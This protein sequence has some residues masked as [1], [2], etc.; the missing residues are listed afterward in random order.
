VVPINITAN[1]EMADRFQGRLP[2]VF[3]MGDCGEPGKLMEAITPGFLA[4]QKI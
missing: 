1:K 3:V 4:V 2:E